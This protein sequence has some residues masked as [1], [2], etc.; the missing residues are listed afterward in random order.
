MLIP[1]MSYS[2]FDANLRLERLKGDGARVK[3]NHPQ[4]R[5]TSVRDVPYRILPFS[6]GAWMF[7][8]MFH[9][10][11]DNLEQTSTIASQLKMDSTSP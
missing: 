1:L 2:T 9:G 4:R 11:W 8:E 6:L 5:G 3:K 7:G 10:E